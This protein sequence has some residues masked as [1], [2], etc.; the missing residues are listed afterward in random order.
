MKYEVWQGGLPNPITIIDAD[1]EPH[2]W[3]I[4]KR[5]GIRNK[6]KLIELVEIDD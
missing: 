3:K 6:S 4:L 1:N 2:A 5:M